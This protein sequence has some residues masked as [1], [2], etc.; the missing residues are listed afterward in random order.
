MTV[1]YEDY[2]VCAGYI[3]RLSLLWELYAAY[4][5]TVYKGEWFLQMRWSI[6][7]MYLSPALDG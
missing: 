3:N 5:Y 7:H 6:Y 4:K 2:I 1:R